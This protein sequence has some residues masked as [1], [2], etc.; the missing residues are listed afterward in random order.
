[1][2]SEDTSIETKENIE[3]ELHGL[4]RFKLIS[5]VAK[6]L[7]GD[8]ILAKD[9]QSNETLR[10]VKKIYKALVKSGYSKD[11]HRVPEDFIKERNIHT[12]LSNIN[13]CDEGMLYT[14]HST[15]KITQIC[16]LKKN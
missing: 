13:N 9:M 6:T 15:Q 12:F 3:N 1:M 4:D 8:I 7:Q 11:N 2:T 5:H 10:V 14:K 16:K